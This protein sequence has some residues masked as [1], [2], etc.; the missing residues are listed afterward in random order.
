MAEDKDPLAGFVRNI[1]EIRDREPERPLDDAALREIAREMGLDG[2]DW[3][4]LEAAFERHLR[5]AGGFARLGNWMD[6]AAEYEKALAI[7]P[8]HPETRFRLAEALAGR[9]KIEGAAADRDRAESLARATLN[10][11]PTHEGALRLVGELRETPA[12]PPAK[13]GS[14]AW[15]AAGI[16][17][18]LLLGGV[19]LYV[20]QTPPKPEPIP[21]SA[22]ATPSPAVP[23]PT[24]QNSA[25]NARPAAADASVPVS[26]RTPDRVDVPVEW[27]DRPELAYELESVRFSPYDD[28]YSCE[29]KARLIPRNTEI[30]SL[31]V[32]VALRSAAGSILVQR[33]ADVW[34][35]HNPVAWP[36]DAIPMGILIHEKTAPPQPGSILVEIATLEK[37]P[38]RPAYPDLAEIPV[39]WEGGRPEGAELIVRKRQSR[40]SDRP[41]AGK[42]H[43]RLEVGVENSGM[44]AFESLKFRIAWT[45]AAGAELGSRDFYAAAQSGPRFAP[46]SRRAAGGTFGVPAA[47]TAPPAEWTLTVV[48][49]RF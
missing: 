20:A 44:V 29:I 15:L 16:L 25:P 24:A 43:H 19:A 40:M 23:P 21:P 22:P 10:A 7:K 6:A 17:A 47:E 48:D 45:D 14:R 32:R 27:P 30:A 9:W 42:F 28:A 8:G 37:R 18:A 26:P 34:A 39:Q 3:A 33:N 36:G 35:D 13:R 38:A 2:A 41:I 11:D 31:S 46:G 1:L 49:A 5:I 12:P 4:R